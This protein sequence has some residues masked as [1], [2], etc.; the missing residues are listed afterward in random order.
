M[1]YDFYAQKANEF[2]TRVATY[3]QN[4]SSYNIL[5]NTYNRAIREEKARATTGDALALPIA[6]PARPCPPSMAYGYDGPTV[7]LDNEVALTS[8]QKAASTYTW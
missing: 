5:A 2:N 1:S 3:N 7:V 8:D 6:I 4:I